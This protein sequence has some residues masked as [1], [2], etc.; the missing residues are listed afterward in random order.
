MS[1]YIVDMLITLV[2]IYFMYYLVITTIELKIKTYKTI[3]MFKIQVDLLY[4]K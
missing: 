3:T 1:G 2:F 4:L